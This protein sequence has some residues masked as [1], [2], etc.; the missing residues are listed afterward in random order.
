MSRVLNHINLEYYKI[1]D[2]FKET[3]SL[4]EK[5]C[6][7]LETE[8]FVIQSTDDTSPIKWHL[9]HTSWFF[10]K[11]VLE[12]FVP[13]YSNF[14]SEFN[15]IFN[16]YYETVGNYLPKANRGV[17]SRP[18]VSE[19][20]EYRKMVTDKI[21]KLLESK[22][23][24]D[25]AIIERIELGINHEQ[26]H[27]ELILMDIKLASFMNNGKISY[28]VKQEEKGEIV[29]QE[30]VP[31]EGGLFRIGNSGQIFS[32]DNEKPE[33]KVYMENF[34]LSSKPV[35]NSEYLTFIRDKG[36]E[37]P[38]FWLSSGWEF[39]NKNSIHAPLY[40]VPN[41]D[42]F[43]VFKFSGYEDIDP[44]EPVSHVSYYEADAY[45]RWAGARLPRE[46]ELELAGS[47]Q[48]I[49]ENQNF[50]DNFHL[51][52][53]SNYKEQ[54]RVKKLFGDIWEWT[55][56]PYTSYPGGKPLSGSLGEY[57][58]K[59]MSN[60]IVLRGGCCLTPSSHFRNTYRNF[61][62]P[63]KRWQVSGIRLAAGNKDE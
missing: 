49:S 20:Y 57:N 1:L 39:I 4:T 2:K 5:L 56:S 41:G 23:D 42:A 46:E 13:N 32:F 29:S 58:Y 14:S 33:H 24:I 25:R 17:M 50:M 63:E 48:I 30:W 44:E 9:G 27:Q 38:E 52:P 40:W 18:L 62:P 21:T 37:R 43:R 22:G 45:A 28:P 19:I 53:S 60:Q 61:Y 59:F 11:F 10:E 55:S 51:S 7:P 16:S 12:N 26:Q 35:T 3:R 47:T 31:F 15:Y 54:N 8:D 36:Y 34:A 6:E